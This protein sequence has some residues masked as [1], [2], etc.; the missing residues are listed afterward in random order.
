MV[1]GCPR[2]FLRRILKQDGQKQVV[3]LTYIDKLSTFLDGSSCHTLYRH[4]NGAGLS[5]TLQPPY[6]WTSI[7][8]RG[9][10]HPPYGY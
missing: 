5:L 6:G 9:F 8:P 10:K 7:C 1:A 3:V 4:P 2:V